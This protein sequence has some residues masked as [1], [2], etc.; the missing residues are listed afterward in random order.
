M[1]TQHEKHEEN[2]DVCHGQQRFCFLQE[3]LE[4][5][6]TGVDDP[7]SDGVAATVVVEDA[8]VGR[9]G[10]PVQL[11]LSLPHPLAHLVAH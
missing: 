8:V 6:A 10:V 4:E 9:P 5:A 2:S 3:D 7:G 1:K 11:L